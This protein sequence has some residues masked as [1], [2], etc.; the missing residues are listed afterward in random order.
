MSHSK[1]KV[2]TDRISGIGMDGYQPKLKPNGSNT[3]TNGY[4]PPKASGSNSVAPPPKKP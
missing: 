1:P 3:S 2:P 4:Q